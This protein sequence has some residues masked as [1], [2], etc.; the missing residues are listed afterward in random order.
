MVLRFIS[1]EEIR[2]EWISVKDRLPDNNRDVFICNYEK[3]SPDY[4]DYA[5]GCLHQGSKKWY[6][7]TEMLCASNY[8]GMA[9]IRIDEK[10]TYWAEI[11]PPK[12]ENK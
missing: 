9:T 10:V 5:V 8:D 6:P 2:M 4:I 1:I 3:D 12:E 11:I 7:C